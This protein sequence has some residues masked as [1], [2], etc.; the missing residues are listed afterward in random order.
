M[1]NPVYDMWIYP[2]GGE[3]DRITKGGGSLSSRITLK[4]RYHDHVDEMHSTRGFR[5]V[6]NK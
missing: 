3:P 5:I 6:R 4:R 1:N 2:T